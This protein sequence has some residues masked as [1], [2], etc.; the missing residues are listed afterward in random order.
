LATFAF[1]ALDLRGAQTIGE[2]DAED[3]SGVAAQL[4]GKGLIVLDIDER[5]PRSAGDVFARFR[6]VKSA[7]LTVMTR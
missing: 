4:R 1:K 5:K 3:K 6:R 7:E 2:M